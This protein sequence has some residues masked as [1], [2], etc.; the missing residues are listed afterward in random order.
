MTSRRKRPIRREQGKLRDA[1]LL[2]IVSEGFDPEKSY[3]ELFDQ[4][5]RR[6]FL[7]IGPEADRSAPVH[8]G[9]RLRT[10]KQELD[11]QPG[12]VCAVLLDKDRWGDRALSQ[13]AK[14]SAG[15]GALFALSNP[16]FEY[17]IMLHF[18]DAA[19]IPLRRRELK[20]TVGRKKDERGARDFERRLVQ[21]VTHAIRRATELD[22]D[23]A[24]RWP[25]TPGSRVYLVMDEILR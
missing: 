6:Q 1:R 23:P 14:D 25:V 16:C 13:L 21:N 15:H 12:D 18:F 17:W 19:E 20:R 5:P 3:F 11:W 24:T 22:T 4:S 9:R 8:L 10:V 7:F 2:L